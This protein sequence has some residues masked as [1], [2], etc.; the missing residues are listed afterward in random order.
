MFTKLQSNIQHFTCIC[1]DK[2]YYSEKA[3]K[4]Q[5]KLR[6]AQKCAKKALEMCEKNVYN[7]TKFLTD[8]DC[9]YSIRHR[10]WKIK[11]D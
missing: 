3:L 5:Q 8:A 6:I 1:H 9:V 2:K 11:T 4:I 7:K 10:V